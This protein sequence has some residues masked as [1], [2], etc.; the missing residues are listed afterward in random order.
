MS[1]TEPGRVAAENACRAAKAKRGDVFAKQRPRLGAIVDKQRKNRAARDR[2]DAK[3]AGA[4]EKV[5]S[6]RAGDR[7]AGAMQKNIEQRLTQSVGGRANGAGFRVGERAPA[8]PSAD[9]AH[10]RLPR[11]WRGRGPGVRSEE[12]WRPR[13]RG[14]AFL[15]SSRGARG[16]G[17]P[18]RSTAT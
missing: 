16:G 2:F 7:V 18:C 11:G 10:Q 9:D 4:G 5:E 6:T 12:R 3:R 14:N 1:G 13:G 17:S 8:Q 15:L